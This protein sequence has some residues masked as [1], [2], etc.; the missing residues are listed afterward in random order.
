MGQSG[1]D[2][3]AST[4]PP[5]RRHRS[6]IIATRG[7]AD[8][9]DIH[10]VIATRRGLEAG[11]RIAL[12][13]SLFRPPGR[14]A[15]PCSRWPKILVY[16]FLLAPLFEW[17]IALYDLEPDAVAAGRK[18]WR[19]FLDDVSG[20][21]TKAA[22]Q[23]AKDYVVF[24]LLAG[25]YV[26]QRRTSSIS[27]PTGRYCPAQPRPRTPA[28]RRPPGLRGGG[29]RAAGRSGRGSRRARGESREGS[30]GTGEPTAAASA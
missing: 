28:A 15:P 13:L 22:R 10:T 14:R 23:L 20:F 9:R 8:A 25:P 27:T 18:S 12:A 30:E 26:R 24:P 19:S 29:R 1:L 2:R 11:G 7:A 17:G 3:R 21:L 6:E 4:T 5:G 16:N